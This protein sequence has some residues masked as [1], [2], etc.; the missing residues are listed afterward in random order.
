MSIDMKVRA[1]GGVRKSIAMKVRAAGGVRK[2]AILAVAA[3]AATL[4]S[5]CGTGSTGSTGSTGGDT[6]T[7]DQAA[8][9]QQL[10]AASQPVGWDNPGPAITVGDAAQGKLLYYIANGLNF[11]FSQGVLKGVK[12]AADAVGLDVVAVDGAGSSAT[13]ARLIEQA[14]GRK[15]SVIVLQSFAADA[16]AA[17]LKQAENAKIK[18]V[19]GFVSDPRLPNEGE[20]ATG[21]DAIVTYCNSCA[22]KLAAT[23][24]VAESG[25]DVKP[26]VFNVPD[27]PQAQLEVDG[28]NNKLKE[29]CPSC[30][31][32]SADAPISQWVTGLPGLTS[33]ALKRRPDANYLF[34]LYDGMVATMKPSVAAAGAEGRVKIVSYNGDQPNLQAIHDKDKVEVAN[35]GAS[36]QWAGWAAVDQALRVLTG[37]TPLTDEKIPNRVF[38]SGNID[39]IDLSKDELTWY[40]NVDVGAEYKKLWGK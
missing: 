2:L 29:L 32:D 12:D 35:V 15:A 6:G 8:A 9:K 40:G 4:I 37:N 5:A 1:A 3:L 38:Y 31:S 39:S 36:L 24:M 20:K 17:P 26:I 18:V 11:P 34:P 10:K 14:I 16:L 25:S 22:G 30:K 28:F 23:Y 21:V 27:V 7:T 13:A 19:L 33:S